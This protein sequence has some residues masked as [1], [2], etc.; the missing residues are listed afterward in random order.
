MNKIIT[1]KYN[2]KKFPYLG[3]RCISESSSHKDNLATTLYIGMPDVIN[4]YKEKRNIKYLI[5][6]AVYFHSSCK[7]RL[8]YNINTY[9]NYNKGVL[10]VSKR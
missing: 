1:F 2:I 8:P 6:M 3:I 4:F 7:H 10:W 9:A 5:F